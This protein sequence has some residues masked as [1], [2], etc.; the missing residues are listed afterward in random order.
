MGY[1]VCV[2]EGVAVGKGVGVQKDCRLVFPSTI[3]FGLI[4]FRVA[5]TAGT[6]VETGL[7]E[8]GSWGESRE[9]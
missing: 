3:G 4:G 2:G 5:S 7:D 8:E 1:G 9:S 6:A